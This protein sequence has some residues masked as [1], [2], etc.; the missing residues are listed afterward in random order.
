MLRSKNGEE[1]GILYSSSALTF[2]GN[3][4][5][6]GMTISE[7]ALLRSVPSIPTRGFV[8]SVLGAA[9]D[10]HRIRGETPVELVPLKSS[11]DLAP[12]NLESQTVA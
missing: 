1:D 11:G 4:R 5:F 3:V 10:V 9:A 7:V 12:Q 2:R 8:R 6:I